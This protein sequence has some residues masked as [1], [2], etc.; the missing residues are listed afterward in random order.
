[1]INL[2]IKQSWIEKSSD[3][4]LEEFKALL[5]E[6]LNSFPSDRHIL[7]RWE[8]TK[9]S[10]GDVAHLIYDEQS[11][12]TFMIKDDM[13]RIESSR[14]HLARYDDIMYA[15]RSTAQQLGMAVFSLAHGGAKLPTPPWLALDHS[16]FRRSKAYADFFSNHNFIP[17]Y[18]VEKYEDRGKDGS[19]ITI[20]PPFYCEDRTDGFVHIINEAMLK[21]LMSKNDHTTNAEFSYRVADS[22]DEF[23]K[24]F[25]LGLIPS[26]FYQNYGRT[27]QII[28]STDFSIDHID[29]KVFIDPYI[30]DFDSQA[31]YTDS[32]GVHLM[33]KIR[34]GEDMETALRRILREEFKV[35]DDYVGAVIWGIDF[36]RDKENLLTPRL[37]V[38]V[39]IRGLA[40]M[41]KDQSHDWTSLR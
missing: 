35:E 1:M 12:L 23:A 13:L 8:I 10:E 32:K 9:I 14:D 4:S 33:D 29:R 6:L 16:M 17:R 25:D 36:D 34:K 7:G 28:N 26:R 24:K 2:Q 40:D 15:I 18:S 37:K 3:G 19:E 22:M 20:N 5:V 30:W 41:Q 21:F 11:L 27:N 31:R 38:N 39:F